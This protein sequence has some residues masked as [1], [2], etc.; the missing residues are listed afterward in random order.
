M[1]MR[2]ASRAVGDLGFVLQLQ[3]LQR[4]FVVSGF[5]RLGEQRPCP[6]GMAS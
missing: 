4:V 2:C 3:Q 6:R 1:P 5:A